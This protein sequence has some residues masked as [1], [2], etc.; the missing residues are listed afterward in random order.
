MAEASFPDTL[1]AL[2]TIREIREKQNPPHNTELDIETLLLQA[3]GG[4]LDDATRKRSIQTLNTRW[5]AMP[6][7]SANI[8]PSIDINEQ[9]DAYSPEEQDAILENLSGIQLTQ[10]CN[11]ECPRCLFGIKKKG[12]T[13]KY[14]F[15]SLSKFIE[16]FGPK[17]RSY[18]GIVFYWDSDPFDYIDGDKTFVDVYKEFRKYQPDERHF[19]ST[20]IPRG[21]QK[22]FIEFLNFAIEEQ[23]GKTEENTTLHLRISATSHGIGRAEATLK[24]A[25]QRL[26]DDG[27]TDDE[28]KHFFETCIKVA[29]ISDMLPLGSVIEQ[30]DDIQ[31]IISPACEDGVVISPREITAIYMNAATVWEPAGQVNIPVTPGN[32]LRKIPER[33]HSNSYRGLPHYGVLQGRL[34]TH[35]FYLPQAMTHTS[36]E[37][38]FASVVDSSAFLIGRDSLAIAGFLQD[39]SSIHSLSLNANNTIEMIFLKGETDRYMNKS[40]E[41]FQRYRRNVVDQHIEDARS[42]LRTSRRLTAEEQKKLDFYITLGEK[43]LAD[44]DYIYFLTHTKAENQYLV[45]AV[46]LLLGKIGEA[47]APY[48]STILKAIEDLKHHMRLNVSQDDNETKAKISTYLKERIGSYFGL[49]MTPMNQMPLWFRC[50]VQEMSTKYQQ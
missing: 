38:P 21:G 40:I 3:E 22:S 42:V 6:E 5:R 24:Q 15:A 12:V 7:R 39:L 16:R 14:S 48:Q 41:H 31:E 4:S 2:V 49:E 11:G 36:D 46:A 29:D 10:G 19:I 13:D 37:I 35:A 45:S 32:T 50:L 27:Y 44:F 43:Y 28:I 17:L 23:K 33:I 9:F 26:L 1:Q 20:S 25:V 47:Q 18:E 30:H 8:T 34:N